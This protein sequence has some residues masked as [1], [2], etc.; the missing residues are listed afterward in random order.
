[1]AHGN[2][3]ATFLAG[4][5]ALVDEN[6]CVGVGARGR[7]SNWVVVPGFG[8]RKCG[9]E[10]AVVGSRRKA[11]GPREDNSDDSWQRQSLVSDF[12]SEKCQ[13]VVFL[14]GLLNTDWRK[15]LTRHRCWLA[16]Y[17]CIV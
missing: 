14:V 13:Q 16:P 2:L 3:L 11:Q 10:E 15:G 6:W 1:M 8:Y 12:L 17:R 9:A 5:T 4:D 7:G